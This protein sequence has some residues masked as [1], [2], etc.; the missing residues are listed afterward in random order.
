MEKHRELKVRVKKPEPIGRA[1]L[2]NPFS[3]NC[4]LHTPTGKAVI[5]NLY[6]DSD[7]RGRGIGRA[8]AQESLE[9]LRDKG[10][11]YYT[12]FTERNNNETIALFE[13]LGFKK[14]KEALWMDC[15]KIY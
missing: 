14:G 4:T 8:L 15:V 13:N 11:L 2:E 7:Y 9:K 5:E 3:R 12:F 1:A 6:V 10:A